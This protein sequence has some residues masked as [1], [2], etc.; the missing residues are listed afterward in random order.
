MNRP[1]KVPTISL[2]AQIE[3]IPGV[4]WA[5]KD[6]GREVQRYLDQQIRISILWKGRVKP[7]TGA[8]NGNEIG[9]LTAERVVQ[10]FQSDLV[11]RGVGVPT[12]ALPLSDQTWFYTI[13]YSPINPLE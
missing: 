2:G 9:P 5:I 10:I 11:S 4:G 7:A 3:H 13:Y 1:Q 6:G 12:P 8:E